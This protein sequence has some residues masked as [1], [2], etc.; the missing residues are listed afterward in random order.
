MRRSACAPGGV[1]HLVHQHVGHREAVTA[2][3]EAVADLVGRKLGHGRKVQA[4][5]VADRVLVLGAI[6]SPQDRFTGALGSFRVELAAE[7][8]VDPFRDGGPFS[9]TGARLVLGRH[10]ALRQEF[11]REPPGLGRRAH[12]LGA[13]EESQVQLALGAR[14]SV[15]L[16]AEALHEGAYDPLVLVPS[17][18]GGARGVPHEGRPQDRC[19]DHK[20]DVHPDKLGARRV[21]VDLARSGR[22]SC[23]IARAA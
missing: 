3:V 7:G 23:G 14:A 18:V 12:L 1:E 5:E 6:E 9:R 22:Q 4:V 19:Q 15:A 10:V 2:V 17:C 8:C 16:D 11:A 20:L 21:H 13:L